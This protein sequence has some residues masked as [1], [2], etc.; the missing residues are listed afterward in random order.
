[1]QLF[2]G[3]ISQL[4]VKLVLKEWQF[5]DGSHSVGL[6]VD[7]QP[8]VYGASNFESKTGRKIHVIVVEARD[9]V[10]K[11]KSGKSEPYVK[12]QYGKVS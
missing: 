9:L 6:R 5:S 12:V 10:G 11:D 4:V 1:M 7:P 8:A 2:F 3:Q